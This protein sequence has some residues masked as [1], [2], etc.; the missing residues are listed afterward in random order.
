MMCMLSMLCNKYVAVVL[1]AE[2]GLILQ[3][4]IHTLSD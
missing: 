3:R 1:P 2:C 4:D